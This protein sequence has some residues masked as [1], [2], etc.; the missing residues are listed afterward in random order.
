MSE[1][2]SG[3]R[4]MDSYYCDHCRQDVEPKI[5]EESQTL[6]N[7]QSGKPLTVF[8]HAAKCPLCG[9]TLCERE[10]DYMFIRAVQAQEGEKDEG[11]VSQQSV[12]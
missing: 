5:E 4:Y 7:T 6:V 12:H 9:K 1:L 2:P 10:F 8:F 11:S 3:D